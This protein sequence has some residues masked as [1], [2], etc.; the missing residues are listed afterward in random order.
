MRSSPSET[1]SLLEST[2]TLAQGRR[3][4]KKGEQCVSTSQMTLRE[5]STKESPG[6][7]LIMKIPD[8]H[9]RPVGPESLRVKSRNLHWTNSMSK[10]DACQHPR[11]TRKMKEAPSSSLRI[12][13]A[14]ALMIST[15]I[16]SLTQ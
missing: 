5:L 6:H 11:T 13:Q 9:P 3:G 2:R 7:L 10:C 16:Q 15:E 12:H 4:N 14:S 8:S 1:P